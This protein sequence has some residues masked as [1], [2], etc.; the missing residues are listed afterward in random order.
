M[1]NCLLR[2][3]LHVKMLLIISLGVSL[4]KTPWREASTVLRLLRGECGC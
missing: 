3:L 4:A 2:A 1:H